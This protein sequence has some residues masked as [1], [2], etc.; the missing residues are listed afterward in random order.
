MEYNNDEYV[1]QLRGVLQFLQ[2]HGFQ[3]AADAV[4]D[5]LDSKQPSEPEEAIEDQ[6]PS[7]QPS[8]EE[9]SGEPDGSESDAKT[10][11][12][13]KSAEPVLTR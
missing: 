9:S 2:D 13:S 7:S 4:Y 10:P 11:Y 5:Q 6:Q 12:R 8:V 3:K 1:D